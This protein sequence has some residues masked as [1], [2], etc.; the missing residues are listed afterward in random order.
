M[1][2]VAGTY[3][4]WGVANEWEYY[5]LRRN[6]ET[7]FRGG[8]LARFMKG[9]PA[10]VLVFGA[11]VRLAY[12]MDATVVVEG[13]GLTDAAIARQPLARRGR[14]GHERLPSP[15]YAV[16]DRRLHATFHR[17]YFERSGFPFFIP[18]VPIRF[19][20][21]GGFLL[22]WDP[23]VLA[24]WKRRGAVFPEF[25]AWLDGTS[26]GWTGSPTTS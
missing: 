13:H 2:P 20:P 24:E 26:T 16:R 10:R 7:D 22:H 19:G 1:R 12:R 18:G 6:A 25:P 14:P 23:V 9:V 4:V 17:N 11:E 21:V 5:S 15:G 8:V 3:F